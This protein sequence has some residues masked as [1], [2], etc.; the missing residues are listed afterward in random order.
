MDAADAES[1]EA[2]KVE[3]T[4]RIDFLQLRSID[5]KSVIRLPRQHLT[6]WLK[7]Q[8]LCGFQAT[9]AGLLSKL[10]PGAFRCDK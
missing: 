7:T 5:D 9:G 2:I 1:A 3:H 8:Y 6:K 4:G 10:G